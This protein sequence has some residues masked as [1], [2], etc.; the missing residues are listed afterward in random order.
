VTVVPTPPSAPVAGATVVTLLATWFA[1]VVTGLPTVVTVLP[2]T[3]G[4]VG[5]PDPRGAGAGE[6]VEPAAPELGGPVWDPARDG[7]TV[8]VVPG[9]TTTVTAGGGP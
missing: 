8:T 9:G 2:T 6:P 5:L 4:A 7:T 1:V 3:T